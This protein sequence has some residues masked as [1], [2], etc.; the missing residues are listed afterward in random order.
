METHIGQYV[1]NSAS[2]GGPEF[3]CEYFP[4]FFRRHGV[5]APF[6]SMSKFILG[7]F[8][9]IFHDLENWPYDSPEILHAAPNR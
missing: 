8:G 7:D 3:F 4:S 9:T 5:G 1:F 2:L 6:A